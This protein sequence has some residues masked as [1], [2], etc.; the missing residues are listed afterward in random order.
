MVSETAAMGEEV[1]DG[2]VCRHPR[3]AEREG[4]V[5]VHHPGVPRNLAV[6]DDGGNDRRR[7]WLGHR[8][9][10]EDGFRIDRVPRADLALP[11]AAG[12]DDLILKDD[13]YPDARE[14]GPVNVAL[15]QRGDLIHR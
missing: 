4:R 12:K 1:G 6:S 2:D 13:A 5:D 9:E 7:E 3:V 10:L 15:R 14:A 8:G 11:E